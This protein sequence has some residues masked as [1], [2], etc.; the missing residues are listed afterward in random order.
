MVVTWWC[1]KQQPRSL[2]VHSGLSGEDKG[3]GEEGGRKQGGKEARKEGTW[4]GGATYEKFMP[5]ERNNQAAAARRMLEGM[6]GR[7]RAFLN[8]D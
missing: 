1:T 7:R 6:R 2:S 3:E 5:T 4:K 8:G